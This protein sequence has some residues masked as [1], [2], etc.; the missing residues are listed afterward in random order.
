MVL[1]ASVGSTAAPAPAAAPAVAAAV[2]APGETHLTDLRMLEFERVTFQH[3]SASSPAV[4]D[5]SF[6][7]Q[8]G[9]T[10]AFVG[11]SGAGKSTLVKLLARFYDPTQ[12]A[13]RIDGHDLRDVQVRFLAE[14]ARQHYPNVKVFA[15]VRNVGFALA[16]SGSN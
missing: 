10:V 14:F 7:V 9:E 13:I 6:R 11:P 1:A 16:E 15:R 2:V 5:I 8:R 4:T 12:G 3:Q